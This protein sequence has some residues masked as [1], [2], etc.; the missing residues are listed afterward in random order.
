MTIKEIKKYLG[1][2][3]SQSNR[4]ELYNYLKNIYIIQERKKQKTFNDIC[5]DLNIKSHASL[6]N[7]IKKT[8][9]YNLDPLFM[10]IK[11]G[12]NE[13]EKKYI[14]EYKKNVYL[15]RLDYNKI[16]AERS[17]QKSKIIIEEDKGEFV[18]QKVEK[19]E[20]PS[21]LE[22]AKNLRHVDTIL[23]NKPYPEWKKKDFE[24]YFKI[25]E[26]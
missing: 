10:L 26:Q 13:K 3:I 1:I 23:N 24:N 7:S 19:F 20:R 5:K 2:D 17:Y 12:Y 16:S 14:E 4:S 18:F 21:I 11:K 25:I 6:I 8:N 22:V 9:I 15:R